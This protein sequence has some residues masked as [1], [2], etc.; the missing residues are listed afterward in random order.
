MAK[1]S[2]INAKHELRIYAPARLAKSCS[3]R[4][5]MASS[6]GTISVSCA[7]T[8]YAESDIVKIKKEKREK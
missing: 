6:S 2:T 1:T 4:P 5:E 8:K 7:S 3:V